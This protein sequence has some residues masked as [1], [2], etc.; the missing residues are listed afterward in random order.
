MYG[1]P[2]VSKKA[3]SE[4]P[5]ASFSNRVLMLILSY[6]YILFLQIQMKLIFI[7]MVEYQALF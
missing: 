4:L 5:L 2:F 1:A 3:I 7:Q 6:D